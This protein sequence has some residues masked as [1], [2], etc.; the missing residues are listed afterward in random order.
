[1]REVPAVAVWCFVWLVFG[2]AIGNFIVLV[3]G[4]IYRHH[5]PWIVLGLAVAGLV[6]GGGL[7]LWR[8]RR[9]SR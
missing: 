7:I 5:R 4:E 8:R 2:H 1:L 3:R 6:I 9:G